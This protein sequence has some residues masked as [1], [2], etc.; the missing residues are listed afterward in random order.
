[1]DKEVIKEL[2]QDDLTVVN[3]TRELENV[4]HNEQRIA[5]IKDDYMTLR[6]LLQEQ[7]N[8]SE[9]AATIIIDFL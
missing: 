7:G 5:Q 2:I 8:A 3:V 9:K 6:N 1:M 4:L